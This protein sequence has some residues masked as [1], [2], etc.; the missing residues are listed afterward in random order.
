M[1]GRLALFWVIGNCDFHNIKNSRKQS[2]IWQMTANVISSK[3]I[4]IMM[5]GTIM[6]GAI[7][8]IAIAVITH[9]EDGNNANFVL[10]LKL[11]EEP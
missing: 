6:M 11:N 5:L 1:V 3:S 4:L 2:F 10:I 8:M 9:K 7:I